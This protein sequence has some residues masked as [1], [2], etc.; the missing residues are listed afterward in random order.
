ME[1]RDEGIGRASEEINHRPATE[2][3]EVVRLQDPHGQAE[4]RR[5][6]DVRPGLVQVGQQN[7][8]LGMRAQVRPAEQEEVVQHHPQPAIATAW[9]GDDEA[10][11]R[12][13]TGHA[14][15][16]SGIS[17]IRSGPRRVEKETGDKLEHVREH[18]DRDG[19]ER[20]RRVQAASR[21]FASAGLHDMD[22]QG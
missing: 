13:Q 4:L 1:V 8:A 9:I 22:K 5:I 10:I 6:E 11:R 3:F 19:E 14:S 18:S 7:H 21:D 17:M 2:R 20:T 16:G 15:A 12:A